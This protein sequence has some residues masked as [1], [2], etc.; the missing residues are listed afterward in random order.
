M[1]LAVSHGKP[2]LRGPPAKSD[3][4]LAVQTQK[5][6]AKCVRLQFWGA[7]GDLLYGQRKD[8]IAGCSA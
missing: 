5:T 4:N 2:G 6:M 3:S 8:G 1:L 7:R